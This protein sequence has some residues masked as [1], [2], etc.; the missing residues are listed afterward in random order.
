MRIWKE[1]HN[2][3]PNEDL[4][5]RLCSVRAF[6]RFEGS[7]ESKETRKA[8]ID[9][10]WSPSLSCFFLVPSSG[11]FV[12]RPYGALIC[13]SFTSCALALRACW[14]LVPVINKC[15]LALVVFL[16]GDDG[17]AFLCLLCNHVA[18]DFLSRVCLSSI[19]SFPPLFTT[20]LIPCFLCTPPSL[21]SC[22]LYLMMVLDTWTVWTSPA[23]PSVSIVNCVCIRSCDTT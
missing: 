6:T 5:A 11:L 17:A 21:L 23:A 10:V 7:S 20:L 16:C 19:W 18:R 4:T 22:L 13:G 12:S 14:F 15:V 8:A 9:L 3:V 1:S 2:A